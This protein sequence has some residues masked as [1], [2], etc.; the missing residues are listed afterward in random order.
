MSMGAFGENFPYTNFHDLNL[1]WIIREFKKF[2]TDLDNINTVQVS[3]PPE[4]NITAQYEQGVITFYDNKGYISKKPVPSGVAITNTEYWQPIMDIEQLVISDPAAWNSSSTYD[5]NTIVSYENKLYLSTQYATANIPPTNTEYW[6]LIYEPPEIPEPEPFRDRIWRKQIAVYGDSWSTQTYGQPWLNYLSEKSGIPVHVQAQG[7]LPLPTIYSTL[8][9]NYNAD[10]YIIE[11][12]LNDCS[13]NTHA[14]VFMN[15]IRS[16]V[17]SIRSVNANAEIYFLTPTNITRTSLL[18]YLYPL[19]FYR[20]CI[21]RLA[22]KYRYNVI[23]GLK[24]TDIAYRDE[25]HPTAET[26][27][28]IGKHMVAA[29]NN[30]GDEETHM[31]EIS[32]LGRQNSQVLFTMIDGTPGIRIQNAAVTLT[33]GTGGWAGFWT[34]GIDLGLH[35]DGFYASMTM[36]GFSRDNAPALGYVHVCY[37]AYDPRDIF[38]AYTAYASTIL[39]CQVDLVVGEWTRYAN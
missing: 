2:Q 36:F 4:W 35:D 27:I 7:S 23:N 11:G 3:D 33:P 13:L 8:W 18:R 21:W 38:V 16:F 25:V 31:N 17:E 34:G 20:T 22:G 1:D 29:L 28:N 14:N 24:I 12:G 5:R 32:T 19:E 37:Y 30:Y 15:A 39:T 9:D 10:I 26:A 6:R